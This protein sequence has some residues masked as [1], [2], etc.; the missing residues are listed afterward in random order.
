MAEAFLK[1]D[2]GGHFEAWSA[3]IEPGGLNPYAVRAMAEAGI[4]ISANAVKSAS[5]VA[6]AGVYF[7]YVVTVCSPEAAER[8][9]LFPGA[10][11]K[12]HWPFEDPAG[13]RGSDEEVMAGVRRVRDGIEAAVGDFIARCRA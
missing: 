12:L 5:D 1:R 2:G 3:G 10:A 4:D 11:R 7:D 13:F 9:P 6:A 8:C